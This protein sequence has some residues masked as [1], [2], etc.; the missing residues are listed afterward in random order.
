MNKLN[1][2]ICLQGVSFAYGQDLILDNVSFEVQANEFWAIIGPNGGGKT[3]LIKLILG[4]LRPLQGLV[5]IFGCAP[6]KTRKLIGYVPQL[7]FRDQLLPLKVFELVGLGFHRPGAGFFYSRRQKETI[8]NVLDQV[9]LYSSKDKQMHELSGGELQRALIARAI[10]DR[11]RL[12][13]FDEPTANV[14]PQ[15]KVCLY[16][17]FSQLKKKM[18]IL[19]VT[20]DLIV[21]SAD[22][23]CLAAVNKKVFFNKQ[24]KLDAKMLELIYGVHRTV[25]PLSLDKFLDCLD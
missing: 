25:C 19:V 6:Q 20:H 1:P 14:D 12:L 24:G 8:F 7:S 22:I 10:V 13:L 18:T 9:G 5:Q 15:G 4:L 17:L 2:A 11:P 21:S 16:E 3:T 23:D